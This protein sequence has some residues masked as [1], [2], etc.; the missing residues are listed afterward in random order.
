LSHIISEEGIAVDPSNVR[1]I[2]KY[3]ASRTVI[4]F[5]SFMG[6]AGY[7]RIFINGFSKIPHP[8]TSL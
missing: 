8:I 7:Y 6:L 3:L 1:V 4:E 5:I 2:Q